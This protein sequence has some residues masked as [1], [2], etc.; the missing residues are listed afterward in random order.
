MITPAR[1]TGQSVPYGPL[2]ANNAVE[3]TFKSGDGM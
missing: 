2:K 3:I 1:I